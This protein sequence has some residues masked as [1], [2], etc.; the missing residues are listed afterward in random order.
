MNDIFG[1]GSNKP[2]RVFKDYDELTKKVESCKNIGQFIVLTS[3]TFDLLHIGHCRYFEKSKEMAVKKLQADPNNV[4]LVVGLD[5]DEKVKEKKGPNRPI[6][7][8]E[9]RLEMLCHTRHVDLVM[10]K[11]LEDPKWNLIEVIKPDVLIISKRNESKYSKEDLD[12][13]NKYC[14]KVVQLEPQAETSTSAK[15]RLL[16]VDIAENFKDKFKDFSKEVK[17][18]LDN[19][20]GSIE[21]MVGNDRQKKDSNE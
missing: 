3:G 9:E 1:P 5:S 19:F 6:T 11:Q 4:V 8:E 20:F 13:L 10:I 14:K 17:G 2:G 15:I 7:P 12:E 18:S 21:E 16:H